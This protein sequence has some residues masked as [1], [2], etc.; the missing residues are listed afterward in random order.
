VGDARRGRREVW[1]VEPRQRADELLD[2]AAARETA[3]RGT[4]LRL[5]ATWSGSPTATGSGPNHALRTAGVRNIVL[6]EIMKL[7]IHT[8]L[9]A[10]SL[11]L[12]ASACSTEDAPV[13]SGAGTGNAGATRGSVGTSGGGT[14][15]ADT[16][17]STGASVGATGGST[18]GSS[19]GAAGIQG[20]GGRGLDSGA[21]SCSCGPLPGPCT[22]GD[23]REAKTAACP[24]LGGY[25]ECSCDGTHW[26]ACNLG[27]LNPTCCEPGEVVPCGDDS[28]RFR[29]CLC[30]HEWSG[31]CETSDAGVVC[32]GGMTD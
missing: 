2:R 15:G 21:G 27:G 31:V 26:L 28:P 17:G 7:R 9:A 32:D 10:A 4:Q 14:T 25:R 11:V 20:T 16:G 22:P 23:M 24:N 19:S 1:T 3:Q 13:Q 8:M 29:Q 6:I 30:N 5:R 18:G 12:E